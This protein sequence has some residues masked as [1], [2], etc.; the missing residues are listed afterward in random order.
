VAQLGHYWGRRADII[1]RGFSGYNSK[2]GATIAPEVMTVGPD[3]VTIFF[4]ANDA[5]VSEAPTFVPIAEYGLNL[6]KIVTVIR[7]VHRKLYLI[8]TCQYPNI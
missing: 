5:V 2:W 6:E 7:K 4:G 1:N 3:L 8:G